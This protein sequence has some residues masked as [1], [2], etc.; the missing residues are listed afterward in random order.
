MDDCTIRLCKQG[1]SFV[2][3]VEGTEPTIITNGATRYAA[4]AQLGSKLDR[5]G[6]MDFNP[7][8]NQGRFSEFEP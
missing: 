1:A 6:I 7:P 2:A 3:V 8:M 5:P 4:L